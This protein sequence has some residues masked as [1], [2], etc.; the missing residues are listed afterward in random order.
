MVAKFW[1][2][3]QFNN[4]KIMRKSLASFQEATKKNVDN[5]MSAKKENVQKSEVDSDVAL[6][7]DLQKLPGNTA[8]Q[9]QTQDVQE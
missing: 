5:N 8:L 9:T 6:L 1:R 3:F 4:N 2:C 7:N